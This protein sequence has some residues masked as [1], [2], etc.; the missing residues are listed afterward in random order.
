M[1]WECALRLRPSLDKLEKRHQLARGAYRADKVEPA[2]QP[3]NGVFCVQPAALCNG[4]RHA[5]DLDEWSMVFVSPG[6]MQDGLGGKR[7]IHLRKIIGA[8][9]PWSG[10]RNGRLSAVMTEVCAITRRSAHDNSIATAE[11]HN[12]HPVALG[13]GRCSIT[14]NAIRLFYKQAKDSSA[15]RKFVQ[16]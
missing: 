10:C 5:P 9:Y 2:L 3:A 8:G 15:D 11:T 6:G 7:F 14:S 12:K 4:I 1:T 16:P 13:R